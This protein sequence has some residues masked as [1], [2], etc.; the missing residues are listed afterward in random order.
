MIAGLSPAESRLAHQRR[1]SFLM[2]SRPSQETFFYSSEP[3]LEN[4]LLSGDRRS[5]T[6]T[7]HDCHRRWF[8]RLTTTTEVDR[9]S[10]YGLAFGSGCTVRFALHMPGSPIASL[11][12][13]SP[14]PCYVCGA[15]KVTQAGL[16]PAAQPVSGLCCIHPDAS[17][18]RVAIHAAESKCRPLTDST[19]WAVRLRFLGYMP[20]PH[21]RASDLIGWRESRAICGRE[22]AVSLAHLLYSVT[23]APLGV[24]MSSSGPLRS[25]TD[26]PRLAIGPRFSCRVTYTGSGSPASL[27]GSMHSSNQSWTDPTMLGTCLRRKRV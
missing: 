2:L 27:S 1:S 14:R 15:F 23:V 8:M 21:S 6:C 7:S 11:S 5:R 16:E 24:T 12:R 18:V 19:L 13:L 17:T 4:L 10:R 9:S 20:R 26:F 22:F 25:A 3:N